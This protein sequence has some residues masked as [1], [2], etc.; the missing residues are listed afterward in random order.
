MPKKHQQNWIKL[1][2][3]ADKDTEA[4]SFVEQWVQ[5]NTDLQVL[6]RYEITK[7]ELLPPKHSAKSALAYVVHWRKALQQYK[8]RWQWREVSSYVFIEVGAI[9]AAPVVKPERDENEPKKEPD[10]AFIPKIQAEKNAVKKSSPVPKQDGRSKTNQQNKSN[11]HKLNSPQPRSNVH[12][13]NENLDKA[14]HKSQHPK[15]SIDKKTKPVKSQ[16]LMTSEPVILHGLEQNKTKLYV[17][18]PL[19]RQK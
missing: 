8:G 14:M 16:L 7:S 10:S 1:G 15:K 4:L 12:P 11:T 2:N 18:R 19:L 9:T 6:N 3:V 13:Q 17:R 5:H